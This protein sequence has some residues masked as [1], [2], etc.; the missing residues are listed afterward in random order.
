MIWYDEKELSNYLSFKGAMG[1][2]KRLLLLSLSPG[3]QVKKVA[4]ADEITGGILP[5][6]PA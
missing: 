1:Q 2:A 6:Q 5:L 3:L 4:D